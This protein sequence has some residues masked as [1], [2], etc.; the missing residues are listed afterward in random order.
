[1]LMKHVDMPLDNLMVDGGGAMLVRGLDDL[2]GHFQPQQIC[3]SVIV[4]SPVSLSYKLSFLK[5]Q[6]SF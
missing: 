5:A 4:G 3:G 6:G 1:M 2:K